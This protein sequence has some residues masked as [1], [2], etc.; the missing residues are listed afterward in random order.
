[1][2]RIAHGDYLGSLTDSAMDGE[3]GPEARYFRCAQ[4]VT[5]IS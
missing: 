3:P 4:Q 2:N 1:M 5:G